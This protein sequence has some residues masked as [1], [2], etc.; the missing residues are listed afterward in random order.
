MLITKIMVVIITS[1]YCDSQ[2]VAKGFIGNTEVTLRRTLTTFS[3]AAVSA[4]VYVLFNNKT[5]Q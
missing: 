5:G 4:L 1:H 3:I 2:T